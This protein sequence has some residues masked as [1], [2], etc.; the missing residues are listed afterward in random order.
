MNL[1]TV[2][3]MLVLAGLCV[4]AW[5]TL[6]G[7]GAAQNR[8]PATIP[9]FGKDEVSKVVIDVEGNL[10]V[11]RR[12]TDRSDAWDVEAGT[13]TL[14][15][16]G[17][18]VDE[19]LSQL[20]RQDVRANFVRA[21]LKDGD[22]KGYGLDAPKDSVE[23]T[24]PQGPSK[25]RYGKRTREGTAVYVDTGE[26]TDVWLVGGNVTDQMR[27]L[28]ATGA[29]AKRLTDLRLYDI[30]KLEIIKGGVTTLEV[31]KDAAQIWN[32]TQPYKGFAEP[33]AFEKVLDRLVNTDVTEWV[34]VGA[35]DLV[36]WGLDKP[37][38]EVHLTPRKGGEPTV[39]LVGAPA[40]GDVGVYVMEQSRAN[41]ALVAKRFSEAVAVDPNSFRDDSFSRIGIDGVAVKVKIGSTAYELRREGSSWDVTAPDRYPADAN[42]VRDVMEAIR[43]WKIVEFLDAA[44]PE[45]FGLNKDADFVEIELNGGAKT[46]LLL[47]QE[48]DRGTDGAAATRYAQRKSSEGDSAVER[49]EGAVVEKLARGYAQFRQRVVRDFGTFLGDLERISRDG[50]RSDEGKEIQTVV[51]DRD[52]AAGGQWGI[53]KLGPGL[54][55]SL[56][57]AG[58]ARVVG[59]LSQIFAKEW[60]FWDPTKDEEMGFTPP[61]AETYSL[62]L[63]FNTRTGTPPNGAEQV[64]MVGKHH[65]NG[66]YYARFNGSVGWAFVLSDEDVR[67][68]GAMLVK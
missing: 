5:F 51:V 13:S 23:I 29:R 31:A 28:L 52:L 6:K 65:P 58:V 41:V 27:S 4:F 37:R 10:L 14:R 44:K 61:L 49:V 62:T 39:I 54:T 25:I 8:L 42:S 60:L 33:Q 40:P 30:G 45:E 24:T 36:K 38:A 46:T 2:I 12:R 3:V 26:G 35:V 68:L 56:D 48:G 17:I 55:G 53:G 32:V 7:D 16:D 20:A 64:L 59:A 22:I 18:A 11:L 66:G 21:Q 63:K 1:R 43:S 67:A 50:G 9:A 57:Q 19:L 15:A 47:G 34:D